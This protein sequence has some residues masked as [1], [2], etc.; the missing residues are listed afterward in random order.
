MAIL[1][2]LALLGG[3]ASGWSIA[4]RIAA[5]QES[6]LV[7]ALAAIAAIA[8]CLLEQRWAWVL[9][10]TRWE[11]WVYFARVPLWVAIALLLG[12][13]WWK[14][15]GVRRRAIGFLMGLLLAYTVV[16]VVAPAFLPLFA[17]QLSA[18]AT[19]TGPY[20]SEVQQSTGWSCG[21]AALAWALRLQGLPASEREMAVLSAT[22]PLHGTSWP[23]MF[24][25]A[26]HRGLTATVRCP[27]TWEQLVQ[28]PKP[29]LADWRL[30]G[31]T[32]HM[33]VVIAATPDTV[34]VGDPLCG[35]MTYTRDEYMSRW[36]RGLMTLQEP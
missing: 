29:L 17:R 25:A 10:V 26:R 33:L 34:T 1:A 30:H 23:G 14:A 36:Q 22:V 19:G 16:E 2:T 20:A 3:V 8:L 9:Q 5:G 11:D 27:S 12:L 32:S 35:K 31:V 18:E 4:R 21:P 6:L 15:A 28:A 13:A 7:T 24:R